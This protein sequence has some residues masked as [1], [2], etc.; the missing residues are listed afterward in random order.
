MKPTVHASG[1]LQNTGVSATPVKSSAPRGRI[2]QMRRRL[3]DAA[4]AEFAENG[5]ERATTRGI[6]ERANCNE[7][8]LF[9][10]FE[11]KQKL[12]GFVVRE[13]AEEFRDSGETRGEMTGDLRKDLRHFAR[14]PNE[15]LERCEGMAR[16]LIGEGS[17]CWLKN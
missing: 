7:V 12:L 6:A 1:H 5:I 4:R 16:A 14:V 10:H 17:R 8:T 2:V 11:S 3:I 15:S 13:T 9:R